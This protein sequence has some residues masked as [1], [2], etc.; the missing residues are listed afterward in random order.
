MASQRPGFARADTDAA[1]APVDGIEMSPVR[2]SGSESS[3][4]KKRNSTEKGVVVEEH[5]LPTYDGEHD[6]GGTAVL[7]TAEDLITNILTVA[8]DPTLNPW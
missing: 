8:D 7:S 4:D 1:T 3:L 6:A 2:A 5:G